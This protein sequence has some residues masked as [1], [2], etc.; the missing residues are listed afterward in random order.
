MKL[1][2][3]SHSLEPFPLEETFL[4]A[5]EIKAD[6]LEL[7]LMP[8]VLGLGLDKVKKLAEK[9]SLPIIN[10]HQPPWGVLFTG[11]KGIKRLTG[12]ASELGAQNIVAHLATM[13]RGFSSPFFDWVHNIEKESGV[14]IAFENAAPRGLESWPD[15]AGQPEKL[16]QFV[17]TRNVN[18]TFDVA[19]AVLK[20]ID[21]YQFFQRHHARIKV[22][23][24]HGFNRSGE[25]HTGLWGGEFDW[26]GFMS[27]VRK[28]DYQGAVTLEI[29][30]LHRWIYFSQPSKSDLDRA[31][32]I[33]KENFE[34]LRRV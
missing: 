5:K 33:I 3:S 30:P 22:I 29:F 18:L 15:Y 24:I 6:G 27:F 9:H 10:I 1:L 8:A 23:H 2:L 28:F 20:G 13:R 31:R 19:K 14:N 32:E 21:P 25:F 34:I 4:L 16:E 12:R 11:K 26:T 17:K 7:V